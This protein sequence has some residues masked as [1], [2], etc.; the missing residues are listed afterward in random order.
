MIGENRMKKMI[1]L[2]VG[3]TFVKHACFAEGRMVEGSLGQFPVNEKGSSD[4]ILVPIR[5]Y[6]KGQGAEKVCVS[7]PGPM[8]YPTGTSH[9]KHKFVSLMDIPMKAYFE[10]TL[11]GAQVDFVH[12][13]VSYLAG[14]MYLGETKGAE[15]PAGVMLGT[16]LGFAMAEEGKILI[17][18]VNTPCP[19]LWNIPYGE[20]IAEDYVSGR[21]IRA[22]YLRLSGKGA[23]V[24]EI[25]QLAREGDKAAQET[26]R[27]AGRVLGELMEERRKSLG[28]DRVILGGQISKAADLLLP[29]AREETSV[30]IRPTA[31]PDNAAL[32]GAYAYALYGQELVR[33]V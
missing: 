31:Y 28:I 21:A 7:I 8:D 23:D 3:G 10:A 9:M 1:A 19:P 22:A 4:E 33:K 25:A 11:P 5:E 20:G 29:P 16:G 17:N 6:L 27:N 15:R 12:D 26:M 24:K 30:E 18:Q 13:G 32:W 2:D 14:V